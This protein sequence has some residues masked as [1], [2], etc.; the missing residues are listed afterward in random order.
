M[1]KETVYGFVLDS[2]SRLK[3]KLDTPTSID[4]GV[5][6]LVG[7]MANYFV[8]KMYLVDSRDKRLV[9]TDNKSIEG[10]LEVAYDGNRVPGTSIAN[11][12]SVQQDAI[13][14]ILECIYTQDTK[15][16][17]QI[18]TILTSDSSYEGYVPGSYYTSTEYTTAKLIRSDSAAK[19]Y[20]FA[21]WI[22]FEFVTTEVDLVFHLWIS[23]EA[24][25]K[26]YPYVTITSV[27]A[28]YDLN[29]LTDPAALLQL[30]VLRILQNSPTYV[31]S[32]TNL[33][34]IS[35]D[36][37][38]IYTFNTTY[39][40]DGRTSVT[41][42]FALA[43]CG[44]KTPSSLDC[45]AAIR[46]YLETNTTL[47]PDDLK[48]LFPDIYVN[49]RF[50]IVPLYD[51]YTSRAGKD[52]YPSVWNINTLSSVATKVYSEYTEE[53]R[54]TYLEAL[55][56]AQSKMVL[57][58]LPDPNNDSLFSIRDAHPTYQ[59]YSSQEAGFKFM[60]GTTQ[61]F[62]VKLNEVM[63]IVNGISTSGLYQQTESSGNNYVVFAQD[64]A[65]YLV[66]TRDSYENI[67]NNT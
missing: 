65:E 60:D 58:A 12:T 41:I 13:F 22:E 5:G 24:F 47:V 23:N 1:E 38:G 6:V 10:K 50:Y 29:V 52:Y 21:N 64:T 42:P 55:T 66:M 33:E 48:I 35:R 62:S 59:D 32:K 11:L 28:P 16:Q 4:Q 31:F 40:V 37:N 17:E 8:N 14:S 25:S 53:F 7:E 56:N 9:S 54:V 36:Q 15:S 49:C 30:G 19:S 3:S 44:A 61:E 46:N 63:A 2:A 18:E 45:R 39:V 67:I 26:Q 27:I 20:K 43:Y 34:T 51:K 57:L